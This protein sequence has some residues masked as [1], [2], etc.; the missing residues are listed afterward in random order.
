M[1][2]Q[3]FSTLQDLINYI[4]TVIITNGTN[5]ISGIEAN[6]AFVGL[7]NFIASYTLNNGLAGISSST[8]VISL[9]K[10]VTIFTVAPT[11][12]SWPDNVQ[13]EY[14]IINGTGVTINLSGG[15]SFTDAYGVTQTTIGPRDAVHIAKAT[16]GS[17]LRINN[18]SG[19]ASGGLPPMTGNS[20]KGLFNNGTSAFWADNV[21][22]IPANDANWTNSTTW[23]NGSS[24][25]LTLPSPHFLI[26]WNETNRFLLN[27]VSPVEYGYVANGF[28]VFT[29]GFDKASSNVFLFFKGATS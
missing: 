11:S 25:T 12:F 16:N 28:Q 9:S 2:N 18:I 13:N 5:S 17:W 10:P 20:G 29:P 26:F 7:G 23:V 4:N 27:T 24:Y 1:P 15:F 19:S 3:T 8:G 22:Q 14:Y 6:N 21:L